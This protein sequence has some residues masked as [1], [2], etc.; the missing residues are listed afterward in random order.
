MRLKYIKIVQPSVG[1]L[2]RVE[3]NPM[4]SNISDESLANEFRS[5]SMEKIVTFRKTLAENNK[6]NPNL[7]AKCSDRF[8]SFDS[9]SESDV[10]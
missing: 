8:T 4:S 1:V 5:F 2:G 7:G 9:V 6:F 3:D 10:L